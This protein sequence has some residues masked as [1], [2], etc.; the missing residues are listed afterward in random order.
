MWDKVE[1]AQGN[2]ALAGEN[3]QMTEVTKRANGK[4]AKVSGK[5]GR[6]IVAMGWAG[7]FKG[8]TQIWTTKDGAMI[9]ATYWL[10]D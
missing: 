9:C 6:W 5:R 10:N 8:K 1:P 7:S 4:W 2:Q 3:K